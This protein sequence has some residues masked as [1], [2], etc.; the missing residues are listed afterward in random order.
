MSPRWVMHRWGPHG[1]GGW[2]GGRPETADDDDSLR[3]GLAGSASRAS[4]R[5]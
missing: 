3:R 1:G 5:E 2:A 4:H